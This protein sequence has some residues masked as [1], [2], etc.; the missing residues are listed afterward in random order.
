V[1][2]KILFVSTGILCFLCVLLGGISESAD[3]T[4]AWDPSP[5]TVEGYRVHY[6]TGTAGAPY[7]SSIPVGDVTTTTVTGL[8]EGLTYFFAVTAYAGA[9]ESGYSNEVSATIPIPDTTA[10]AVAISTP[11]ADATYTTGTTPVTLGGTASDSAGV[12]MVTWTSHHGGTGTCNGTASWSCSGI[13]LQTGDN[14]ITISG[15]D[16]AGNIGNDTL[17]VTYTLPPTADFSAEVTSAEAPLSVKFTDVS[18]GT[19]TSRLWDFGDGQT[20]TATAPNHLYTAP[21]LY[22]VSLT[23]SGPG[24]EHNKTVT[25]YITV[26]P[27]SPENLRLTPET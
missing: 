8:T 21:G 24:G 15:A 19:I 18:T 1:K 16:A 9:S 20:S 7:T 12:T 23:V 6:R 25:D 2:R 22:T 4:L 3:V 10:P 13:A 11:T 14:I 27:A 26:K 5:S 17:T